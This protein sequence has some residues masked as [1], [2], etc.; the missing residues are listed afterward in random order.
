MGFFVH[1][2]VS[3]KTVAEITC[4][5]LGVSI[6]VFIHAHEEL[7]MTNTVSSG[8]VSKAALFT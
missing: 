5:L 6:S 1:F 7:V 2:Q 3:F 4:V 8:A